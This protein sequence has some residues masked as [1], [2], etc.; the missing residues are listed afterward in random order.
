MYRIA[1]G[2]AKCNDT[3]DIEILVLLVRGANVYAPI[4][5]NMMK[6]HKFDEKFDFLLL[7]NSICSVFKN[8]VPENQYISRRLLHT[9]DN[10]T[11][12][13]Y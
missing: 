8:V 12:F 7:N 10:R 2:P 6:N 1:L 3:S 4:T 5:W 11:T 9:V 13:S